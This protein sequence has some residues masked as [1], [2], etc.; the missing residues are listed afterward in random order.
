DNI[1]LSYPQKRLFYFD[2]HYLDY[3]QLYRSAGNFPYSSTNPNH[4]MMHGQVLP[5]PPPSTAAPSSSSFYT[6]N[7]F[8][9]HNVYL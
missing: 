9:V 5:P 2:F 4:I 6:P 1:I 3:E 7:I 8:D